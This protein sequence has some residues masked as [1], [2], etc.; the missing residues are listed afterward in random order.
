MINQFDNLK[1][2]RTQA[3][4]FFCPF[5]LKT[6]YKIT[7]LKSCK[8][9]NFVFVYNKCYLLIFTDLINQILYRFGGYGMTKRNDT[10]QLMT[11]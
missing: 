7:T 9:D 3:R 11:N 1:M 8:I 5:L 2:P 6:S 10:N 4:H